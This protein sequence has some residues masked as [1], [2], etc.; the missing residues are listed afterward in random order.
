[1]ATNVHISR[2]ILEKEVNTLMCHNWYYLVYGRIYTEDRKQYQRFKFVVWFDVFDVCEYYDKDSA[3]KS[4][5]DQYARELA[6]SFI[7]GR[8]PVATDC[9][10]FIEDCNHT[11]NQYNETYNR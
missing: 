10:K 3:S 2:V 4:E 5:I 1:M 9:S 8:N 6:Q 7:S 11:I